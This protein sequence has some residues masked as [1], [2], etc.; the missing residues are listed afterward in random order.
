MENAAKSRWEPD[1]D[2]AQGQRGEEAATG[3][4]ARF[5]SNAINRTIGKEQVQRVRRCKAPA[6]TTSTCKHHKHLSA[7]RV[8]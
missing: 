4:E 5:R 6:S 8:G 7:P 2:E 3:E 1:V